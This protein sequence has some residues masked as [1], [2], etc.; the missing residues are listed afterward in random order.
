MLALQG[1]ERHWRSQ[2]HTYDQRSASGGDTCSH[3]SNPIFRRSLRGRGLSFCRRHRRDGGILRRYLPVL[4]WMGV[5]FL[6][7]TGL[8]RPE[9][10][11]KIVDPILQWLGFSQCRSGPP[12][13]PQN[14]ACRR[15]FYFWIIA[16]LF[17]PE[18]APGNRCAA[19]G[20]PWRSSRAFIYACTDEFHQ[21]F[22]PERHARCAMLCS[23]PP[24]PPSRC[25]SS[26]ARGCIPR[27]PVPNP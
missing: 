1:L 13:G 23:T 11:E 15:V 10:S 18:F 5:I 27:F 14:G 7:S 20:L 22:V 21:I 9:N 8:G 4:L 6:A 12:R 16:L 25:C 2:C 24:A 3:P 19:G 17:L 26:P